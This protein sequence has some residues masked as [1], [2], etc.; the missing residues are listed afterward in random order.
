MPLRRLRGAESRGGPA[1]QGGLRDRGAEVKVLMGAQAEASNCTK[2]RPCL[3]PAQCVKSNDWTFDHIADIAS[4]EE[5]FLHD[6]PLLAEEREL[7]WI[8]NDAALEK[9]LAAWSQPQAPEEKIEQHVKK[10]MEQIKARKQDEVRQRFDSAIRTAAHRV[11]LLDG[12]EEA[13]ENEPP[14]TDQIEKDTM[15]SVQAAK[16]RMELRS[17]AKAALQAAA[18]RAAKNTTG[19]M[20]T[21]LIEAKDARG[22]E[23]TPPTESSVN[24]TPKATPI[25]KTGTDRTDYKP[26]D[27][28]EVWSKSQ[29]YWS[30]GEVES[31]DESKLTIVYGVD[32]RHKT[33]SKRSGFVRKAPGSPTK[34]VKYDILQARIEKALAAAQSRS[35]NASEAA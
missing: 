35:R 10:V 13:S 7:C 19:N 1:L 5:L 28:V 33:L 25:Y 18:A 22:T 11:D 30:R 27:K 8:E 3:E 24:I 23:N 29:N 2:P 31:V 26:G 12:Y 20:E 32:P 4:L 9:E 17:R 14:P 6:G 16:E 34:P 15:A 21:T